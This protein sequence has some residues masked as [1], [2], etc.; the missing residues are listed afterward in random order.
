M[1]AF[2]AFALVLGAA[3]ALTATTYDRPRETH[4]EKVEARAVMAEPITYRPAVVP[5]VVELVPKQP[6][7]YWSF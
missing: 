7:R 5:A 3:V 2:K 1:D 4:K 6:E